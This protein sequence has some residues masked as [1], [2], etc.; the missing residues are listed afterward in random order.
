MRLKINYFVFCEL[1]TFTAIPLDRS[2]CGS[3]SQATLNVSLTPPPRQRRCSLLGSFHRND[4][5]LCEEGPA[6]RTSIDN[7]TISHDV[8]VNSHTH[9]IRKRD[10]VRES[11][12]KVF[13][14]QT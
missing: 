14:R 6:R 5:H 2:E 8:V 7:T 3:L 1:Q 11:T 12:C 10:V 4:T 9:G 13:C